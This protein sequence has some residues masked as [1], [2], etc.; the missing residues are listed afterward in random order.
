MNLQQRRAFFSALQFYHRLSI[1]VKG[2]GLVLETQY[3]IKM[4]RHKETTE[5]SKAK[6]V[7]ASDG[8]VLDDTG[9]TDDNSDAGATSNGNQLQLA[10]KCCDLLHGLP[11]AGYQK[12]TATLLVW[13]MVN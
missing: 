11:S 3:P 12:A 8:P 5:R 2:I 13:P 1:G 7:T 9:E 4:V 10:E 6:D